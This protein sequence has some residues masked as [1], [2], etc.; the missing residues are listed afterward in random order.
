[1]ALAQALFDVSAADSARSGIRQYRADG[2]YI[3]ASLNSRLTYLVTDKLSV[4]TIARYSRL[5][6][7]AADSPVVEDVGDAN[8][9][10]GSL[11]INYQF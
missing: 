4:S 8:Q 11:A 2:E 7:D 6:G 9:W 5:F 10:H 1:M 3:R